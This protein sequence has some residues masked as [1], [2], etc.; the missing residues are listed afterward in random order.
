[1][2]LEENTEM[3]W[4]RLL[5]GRRQGCQGDFH[6]RPFLPFEVWTRWMYSLFLFI[7]LWCLFYSLEVLYFFNLYY[8]INLWGVCPSSPNSWSSQR[9]AL[10]QQ[11]GASLGSGSCLFGFPLFL[12]IVLHTFQEAILALKCLICS[13]CTLILSMRTLPFNW[14]VHNEANSMLGDSVGSSSLAMVMVVGSSFLSNLQYHAF[15]FFPQ[16]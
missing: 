15:F 13:I 5:L 14:L 11:A 16:Y 3:Q 1:M 4:A 8:V 12:A 7:F 9:V 6:H 10:T 2:H